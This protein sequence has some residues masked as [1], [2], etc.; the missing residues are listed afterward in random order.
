MGRAYVVI[1][2]AIEKFAKEG[3]SIIQD[4]D[5]TRTKLIDFLMSQK[6]VENWEYCLPFSFFIVS[7]QSAA[8]ISSILEKEFGDFRHVVLHI[9][10]KDY[11][12]RLPKS[13]W[14]MMKDQGE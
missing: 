11:N 14:D 13:Y 5:E 1:F 3:R 2:G 6:V 10:K 12:G 7:K 4:A 8:Q 9:D